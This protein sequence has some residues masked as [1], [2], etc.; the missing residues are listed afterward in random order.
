VASTYMRGV[1][2][3]QLPTTVLAMVDSSVGGKTAVNTRYGKNLLGTFWQ[4]VGVFVGLDFLQTLP[5]KEYLNGLAEALKIAAILDRD[6]FAFVEQKVPQIMAR[7]RAVMAH[8]IARCIDLKRQ[9]VQADEEE[10][11]YRQI[12]NF[13]HTIGHAL[14]AISDFRVKHGFCIS[15]GM[16]AEA[17]LATLAHHLAPAEAKRLIYLQRALNLPT[18]LDHNYDYD[19]LIAQMRSD[20]KAVNQ[21]P[22]FVLLDKIGQVRHSG[23]TYSF[24]CESEL[25]KQALA[26]ID[27]WKESVQ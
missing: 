7:D 9:V 16:A 26:T 21:Q 27:I 10:S 20:K 15:R 19:Q 1:P 25:I 18:Q 11:G 23:N 5:E 22:R 17:E 3:I 2:V 12:L 4:P 14:E 8:L 24:N 6:L 13:G